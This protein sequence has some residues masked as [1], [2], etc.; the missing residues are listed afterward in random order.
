MDFNVEAAN[1]DNE[2]RIK[3][4]KII[5]EEIR[6]TVKTECHHNALEFG[7]GTGLISFNLYDSFNNITLVDTSSG[8]ID[9]VNEKIQNIRVKNMSALQIDISKDLSLLGKFDV[10]Y[11]SMVLHHIKDTKTTLKSLYSLLNTGGLLCI[12]DLTEDDGTFHKMD[13]NFDG[14]NGFNQDSLIKLLTEVGFNEAASDVFYTG[15]N[16]IDGKNYEYSLFL[17]TA[18][19]P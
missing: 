13:K 7:C 9:V 5:A 12:I 4:A 2:R 14:H 19:K 18:R 15:E 8:M 11:T 6:N 17:M 1:W 10:I 16:I 3:R